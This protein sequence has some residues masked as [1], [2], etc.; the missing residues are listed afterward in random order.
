M[1][2]MNNYCQIIIIITH[3]KGQWKVQ[4]LVPLRYRFCFYYHLPVLIIFI[5]SFIII[6]NQLLLCKNVCVWAK[7]V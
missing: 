6:P 2:G 5:L 3:C 1:N 7:G 4:T